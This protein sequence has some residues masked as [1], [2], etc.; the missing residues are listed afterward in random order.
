MKEEEDFLYAL[1]LQTV[2]NHCS[3]RFLQKVPT[4]WHLEIR[5]FLDR[6]L[7]QH[8]ICHTA[9]SDL[10]LKIRP[11]R[12]PDLN[13]CY[14]K[15]WRKV[16]DLFVHKTFCL[17]VCSKINIYV[18]LIKRVYREALQSVWQYQAYRIDIIRIIKRSHIKKPQS[19]SCFHFPFQYLIFCF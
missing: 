16:K 11:P 6:G 5:K 10:V 14:F 18:L 17:Q 9:Y 4:Y 8:W 1:S 2:S 15:I 13:P 3:E 19:K 12:S 7:S